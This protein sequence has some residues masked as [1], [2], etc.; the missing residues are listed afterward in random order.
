MFGLR[1]KL[2]EKCGFKAL[3]KVSFNLTIVVCTYN[4]AELLN[5][6]LKSLALQIGNNEYFEIIVVDNNSKD[7]TAKVVQNYIKRYK[8]FRIVEETR[9]GLAYSRNRGWEEAKGKWVAYIDDD[10]IV[11]AD[12][13]NRALIHIKEGVF[14]CIGGAYLPWYRDGRANWYKDAYG[15]N[16]TVQET[17]GELPHE[18]FA[19]GGNLLVLRS[20]IESIGGFPVELGMSGD[21]I[22]YGEDTKLQ[23]KLRDAGFKVG[24]DP[25]LLI[26]HYVAPYKQNVRWFMK[27]AAKIGQSS[28]IVHGNNVTVFR[29]SI[30]IAAI[31]ILPILYMPKNAWKLLYLHDYYWQNFVIDTFR[32]SASALG[33][34]VSGI[35]YKISKAE[36]SV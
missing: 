1:K 5:D 20:A 19:S 36:V 14:H 35:K 33:R 4:R 24:F 31:V 7:D 11:H 26:D 18:K 17:L 34:V 6:L 28:W 12:Y 16:L 8:N 30:N 10:A 21:N 22:S 9:Q 13:I 23:I 25:E 27:S 29:L 3:F 15:S 32:R 2:L